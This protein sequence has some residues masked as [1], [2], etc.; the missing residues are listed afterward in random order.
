MS[1]DENHVRV[2]HFAALKSKY[3][4]TKYEDSSPSSLLYLILRKADLGIELT[5]LELDW[6]TKCKLFQTIDL[7]WLER[8]RAEEP[9]RLESEFLELKSKYK[10][11]KDVNSSLSS[12]LYPLLW[13]LESE[14]QLSDSE[15]QLLK[16][17]NLVETVAIA[18][19]LAQFTTLKVKY[20]ATNYQ[21]SSLDSPLYSI[22]RSFLH[23]YGKVR[24][25]RAT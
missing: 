12:F 18:Q 4:A 21:D 25:Q 9:Q 14:H 16:D 15:I 1:N 6:L 19:N 20:Q 13:Q 7:I 23:N 22:P 8:H 5:K 17:N 2:N 11:S 3:Q 24:E 10:V